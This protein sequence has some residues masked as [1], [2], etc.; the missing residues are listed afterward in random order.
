[1]TCRED[2]RLPVAGG[3]DILAHLAL[4]E[5]PQGEAPGVLVLHEILG[6]N[7][8][9]RRIAGR[10]AEAGYAALAPDLFEGRG[11]KPVCIVR[12]AASVSRGEGPVVDDM[13]AAR[14]WLAA[15]PQVDGERLAVAGFCM[16]GGFALLLGSLG[17]FR[18]A[19]PHYGEV[20]PDPESYR[21]ICPVVAGYG[22]R[23]L[24]F[25]RKGRLLKSHLEALG[26]PHDVK[27][28]DEAGHSYMSQHAP[29]MMAVAPFTPLRARYH[30]AAAEDSWQRILAFFRAHLGQ[31][32]PRDE[33]PDGR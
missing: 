5:S 8:D 18:V 30:E 1:M 9:I 4:P 14:A 15:H 29:W 21:D 13:L 27:I 11:P 17:G 28:Y 31:P 19:T 26:V 23:D 24:V 25:A 32:E 16:G 22:G 3:R 7:A 33:G 10:F 2:I 20:K 6:L 12:V